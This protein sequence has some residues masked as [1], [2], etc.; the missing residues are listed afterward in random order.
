MKKKLT[1]KQKTWLKIGTGV[2]VVG[3]IA[4]I[5]AYV[6]S[7][8]R[9]TK[10]VGS[11]LPPGKAAEVDKGKVL[12]LGIFE[13]ECEDLSF[14]TKITD[15]EGNNSN[16]IK[17]VPTDE[18]AAIVNV[19]EYARSTWGKQDRVG[20]TSIGS[21]YDIEERSGIN[22]KEAKPWNGFGVCEGI[23]YIPKEYTQEDI[24]SDL[25]EG[26][27]VRQKLGFFRALKEGAKYLV[28]NIPLKIR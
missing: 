14:N 6:Y 13:V 1:K 11:L 19:D 27:V 17:V 23:Y 4:G 7:K 2:A 26:F 24:K 20:C 25:A 10:D 21:I 18:I 9:E 3:S 28:G 5:G 15:E 8:L 12:G 22:L 16:V